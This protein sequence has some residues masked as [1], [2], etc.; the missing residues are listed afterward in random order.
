MKKWKK[1]GSKQGLQGAGNF[2]RIGSG[3]RARMKKDKK[4]KNLKGQVYYR[5]LIMLMSNLMS[6]ILIFFIVLNNATL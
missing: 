2:G 1:F 4:K 5:S 6:N 3:L